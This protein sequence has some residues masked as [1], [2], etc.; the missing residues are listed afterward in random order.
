MKKYQ[1]R[2]L[3]ILDAL[4]TLL[5]RDCEVAAVVSKRGISGEVEVVVCGNIDVA[6]LIQA[7]RPKYHSR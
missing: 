2:E 6:H 7:D 5:V 1:R 3:R 4:A